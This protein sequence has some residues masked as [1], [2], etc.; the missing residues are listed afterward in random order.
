MASPPNGGVST[1]RGGEA[2]FNCLGP[3]WQLGELRCSLGLQR[4]EGRGVGAMMKGN[5]WRGE[6]ERW[7]RWK[8][9]VEKVV[10][11]KV[12]EVGEFVPDGVQLVALPGGLVVGFCGFVFEQARLAIALFLSLPDN[13][14]MVPLLKILG[15]VHVVA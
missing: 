4:C 10:I 13:R 6:W 1:S 8:V 2:K 3:I 5:G 11:S 7:R 12:D 14:A 9:G 15:F